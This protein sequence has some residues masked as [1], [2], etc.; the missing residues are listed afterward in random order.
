VTGETLAASAF[1]LLVGPFAG[2]YVATLAASWPRAP[3]PILGRS[4][5]ARCGAAIAADHEVPILSWLALRGRRPCCGGRIPVVYPLG[6]AAGLLAGVAAALQPNPLTGAW[7]FALGLALAYVALVDLRR[8]SIPWWGL[9]ALALELSLAL[10]TDA[11]VGAKLARLA[12]G[13]ALALAFEALRRLFGRGG[14]AGLGV[15]DVMLAG[16]LGGLVD[17]RLAA[18]MVSLAALAPLAIQYVR[19]KRGA[20]PFGFWLSVS[21]A[22]ILLS[23]EVIS[24]VE[25]PR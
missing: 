6:E 14:R 16:L 22:G 12:T 18:P 4:R 2:D 24:L 11:T 25:L 17:W 20:V 9:A 1:F 19:R 8:F 10:A 3:S 15:G 13:G 7:T 23:V 5:C 21:T